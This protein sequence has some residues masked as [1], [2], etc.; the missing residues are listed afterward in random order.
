MN[1][2][3][4]YMSFF[5]DFTYLDKVV[6]QFIDLVDEIIL[7]DGPNFSALPGFA[8]AGIALDRKS[9]FKDL[10]SNFSYLGNSKVKYHW[11]IWKNERDKRKHA[12]ELCSGDLILT[13]DA[14]E[15]ID[16][17]DS[18]IKDFM[19]SEALVGGFECLNMYTHDIFLG[20]DFY[21]YKNN[22]S[23]KNVIFRADLI[24]ANRHLD[25]L[26]LV[27]HNSGGINQKDL[28][29]A[30]LGTMYHVTSGRSQEGK[31]IKAIFYQSFSREEAS[32]DEFIRWSVNLSAS[33]S[34]NNQLQ[35]SSNALIGFPLDK[36]Y[37]RDPYQSQR[38]KKIVN[39]VKEKLD[40]LRSIEIN[41]I[42]ERG[43]LE[44]INWFRLPQSPLK[45][46]MNGLSIDS[47]KVYRILDKE[48]PSQLVENVHS[49]LENG[50][51]E[52]NID[53]ESIDNFIACIKTS[54]S[55]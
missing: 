33:L 50:D 25:Y 19:N 53:A 9:C 16:F 29:S 4:V 35:R 46:S 36:K 15:I 52:I 30:D 8:A 49:K 17:K 28:C 42:F 40:D 39:Y 1:K 51:L 43:L 7:V 10:E 45:I 22:V 20:G 12:Y 44:G 2:I 13:V 54:T 27:N 38:N 34:N 5:R 37:Y 55:D 48:Q 26:W 18:F 24:D 6:S 41:S 3:S 11:G 14:D 23:R 21:D 32:M 47:I 31:L